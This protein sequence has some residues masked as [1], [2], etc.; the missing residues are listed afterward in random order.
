MTNTERKAL[1]DEKWQLKREVL[2]LGKTIA[3]V[4]AQINKA[5]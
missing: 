5:K 1:M 2:E 4:E 3:K